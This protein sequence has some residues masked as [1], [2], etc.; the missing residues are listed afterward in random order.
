MTT[1]KDRNEDVDPTGIMD[2]IFGEEAQNKIPKC[3]ETLSTDELKKLLEKEPDTN[4]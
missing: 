1:D 2:S 3:K 4:K